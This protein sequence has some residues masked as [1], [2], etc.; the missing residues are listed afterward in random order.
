MSGHGHEEH[1]DDAP[2]ATGNDTPTTT[3]ATKSSSPMLNLVFLV[4]AVLLVLGWFKAS[5]K[6]GA[7]S[8]GQNQ[9][10]EAPARWFK[11]AEGNIHGTTP[12]EIDFD[13]EVNI[14]SNAPVRIKLPGVAKPVDWIPSRGFTQFPTPG[15]GP[16]T[17]WDPSDSTSG[18]INFVLK[19]VK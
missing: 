7:T 12:V 19:K 16:R 17:F 14:E 10:T 18:H 13:W 15:M 8:S 6:T 11:D 2:E 5:K 9:T 4:I 1:D 3:P